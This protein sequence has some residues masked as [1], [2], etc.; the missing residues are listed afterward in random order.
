MNY[1]DLIY[2]IHCMNFSTMEPYSI[3]RRSNQELI[4]HP[5]FINYG[6]NKIEFITRLIFEGFKFYI[7]LQDFG[8]DIPHKRYNMIL[9]IILR[10][11]F[12]ES[13]LDSLHDESKQTD[14]VMNMWK[15]YE[16]YMAYESFL[17][18]PVCYKH[19]KRRS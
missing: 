5:Y 6:R 15:Y 16:S 18:F 3:I 1:T 17:G 4:F 10:T 13:F 9:F 19:W 8:F 14:F 11:S 7:L 2:S 12:A